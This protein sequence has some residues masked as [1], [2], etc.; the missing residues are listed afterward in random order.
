M[1]LLVVTSA[2]YSD[3]EIEA[4]RRLRRLGLNWEPRV[5]HYVLDETGICLKGSPFQDK[6]YFILN[7]DYFMQLCGGVVR[8]KEVML[9]LPTWEDLRQVI[10]EL[11]V[12]DSEVAA[13]LSDRHA[14]ESG[15]ERLA[16]YEL[17]ESRFSAFAKKYPG[18]PTA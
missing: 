3:D 1:R 18:K 6:V 4:A 8:C 13:Y 14:V 5:G 2:M 16:L 11:G 10:Q 9:W 7:Y 15:L 12:C 17:V